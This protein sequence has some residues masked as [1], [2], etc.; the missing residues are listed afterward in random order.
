LIHVTEAAAALE[1][2]TSSLVA[3]AMQLPLIIDAVLFGRV[4]LSMLVGEGEGDVHS[5]DCRLATCLT[6]QG[7]GDVVHTRLSV[8]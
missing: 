1:A 8:D 3:T 4:L 7:S 2:F 6:G 5:P